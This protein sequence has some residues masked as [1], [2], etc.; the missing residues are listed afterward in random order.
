MKGGG[1]G[2]VCFMKEEVIKHFVLVGAPVLLVL[3]Q[4]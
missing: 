2:D 3:L 1:G 4:P